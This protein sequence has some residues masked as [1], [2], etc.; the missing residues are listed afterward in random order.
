MTTV[1]WSSSLMPFY[2]AGDRT[3]SLL[4][5]CSMN[6]QEDFSDTQEYSVVGT[7]G[8]PLDHC[9]QRHKT[10]STH[11]MHEKLRLPRTQDNLEDIFSG[12][13]LT[14]VIRICLKIPPPSQVCSLP[15]ISIFL[16][17]NMPATSCHSYWNTSFSS[18]SHDTNSCSFT[19]WF[20]PSLSLTE[21]NV[22][23]GMECKWSWNCIKSKNEFLNSEEHTVWAIPQ[24][25]VIVRI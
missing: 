9:S 8:I 22:I 17:S 14:T 16:F 13:K 10:I 20:S 19:R 11:F 23:L 2:S 15:S 3:Y 1:G 6:F 12:W 24:I 21:L 25:L 18:A 5:I 4:W 7:G